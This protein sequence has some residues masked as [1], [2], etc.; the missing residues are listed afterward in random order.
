MADQVSDFFRSE[1]GL[2]SNRVRE[3]QDAIVLLDGQRNPDL[4][5]VTRKFGPVVEK[6]RMKFEWRTLIKTPQTV[7]VTE[8][9]AA[10][11]ANI[12]V[13]DYKYIHTDDLLYNTRTHELMLAQITDGD[14]EGVS[15][16][17]TIPIYSYSDA[18]GTTVPAT[19]KYATEVGD[20]INI[21]TESHAEGEEFAQAYRMTPEEKYDYIMQ[22]ARRSADISDIAMHEVDRD[23]VQQ[24]EYDNKM[25]L[26]EF[27]EA[28]NRLFWLSQTTREVTTGANGARRH[29][30]GGLRQKIV[31]NRQSLSGVPGGLTPQTIGE[32]LRLTKKHTSSAKQ[33]V[34]L[35]GQ[36]ATQAM[37][38]WPVGSVRTTP[39]NKSWGFDVR[40][41]ITPYGDLALIQ[42]ETLTDDYGLADI[43]AIID[44]NSIRQVRLIGMGLQLIKKIASLSTSCRV[45]DGFKETFGMQLQNEENCAFI[46]DIS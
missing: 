6:R 9:D 45:A 23:P 35:V 33:K 34:C 40:T 22:S 46:E 14:S 29:A 19:L 28:K 17:A 24:R 5:I 43:M 32:A 11:Q 26:I 13:D 21:L 8:A 20:V 39:E 37:S 15:S 44:K 16:S 41:V 2:A 12:V 3:M 38:A 30:M 42:D 31:T 18:T 4:E 1:M 10:G 7:K 27:Y 36:Y 25:A